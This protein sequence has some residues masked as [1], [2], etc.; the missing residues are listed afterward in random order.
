MSLWCVALPRL[1]NLTQTVKVGG[2]MCTCIRGSAPIYRESFN[3][4]QAAMRTFICCGLIRRRQ[5]YH[6]VLILNNH[7]GRV[8]LSGEPS[9][10]EYCTHMKYTST[11]PARSQFSWPSAYLID[12]CLV[13]FPTLLSWMCPQQD[14]IG[15]DYQSFHCHLRL[16]SAFSTTSA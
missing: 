6:L 15:I 13:A 1:C 8:A 5:L 4:S 10:G 11:Y 2:K 3:D 14:K 16:V 7:V 9:P 12:E